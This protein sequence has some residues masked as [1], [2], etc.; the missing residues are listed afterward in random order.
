MSRIFAVRLFHV[1]KRKPQPEI[2]VTIVEIQ[3][4]PSCRHQ[5]HLL[6]AAF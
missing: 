1:R 6:F 4:G 3:G 5:L 2:L